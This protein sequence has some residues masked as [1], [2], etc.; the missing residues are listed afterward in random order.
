MRILDSFH[1][2]WRQ[3]VNIGGMT[4]MAMASRRGDLNLNLTPPPEYG[5]HVKEGLKYAMLQHEILFKHQ[6]R[7][8]H[9]LY[10]TQKR[11]MNE[12]R[13]S[14]TN[15][16]HDEVPVVDLVEFVSDSSDEIVNA[17]TEETRSGT[18]QYA[19]STRH[20]KVNFSTTEAKVNKASE[21]KVVED[22][23]KKKKTHSQATAS[24]IPSL[25]IRMLNESGCTPLEKFLHTEN[26][27]NKWR[28]IKFINSDVE[29]NYLEKIMLFDA[30]SF[31]FASI[32]W[33]SAYLKVDQHTVLERYVCHGISV[34]ESSINF[35]AD[36]L[37]EHGGS[38]FV[39][40]STEKQRS[41]Y[42]LT[43]IDLNIAQDDEFVN[44]FPDSVESSTSPSPK[45]TIILPGADLSV[46]NVEY[47]KGLTSMV[48]PGFLSPDL[49][50][51]SQRNA[52]SLHHDIKVSRPCSAQTSVQTSDAIYH[53]NYQG[54]DDEFLRSSI[55]SPEACC[56][57]LV[58]SI[59]NAHGII[60]Q[61]AADVPIIEELCKPGKG[62]TFS[63]L[64]QPIIS[65]SR[66]MV[67]IS[68]S[69]FENDCL[70]APAEST[71]LP[72]NT[73][74][75]EE[76]MLHKEESEEDTLSSH[77]KVAHGEQQDEPESR[78]V[79]ENNHFECTSENG[80]VAK[81]VVV[82]NSANSAIELDLVVPENIPSNEIPPFEESEPF[83]GIED[84]TCH[85]CTSQ[86]KEY[87]DQ[88]LTQVPLMDHIVAK[89]AKTL[90][91]ISSKKPLYTVDRL[92][93]NRKIES[94]SEQGMDQPQS[95]D[96]F[97][98]I[99]LK[100]KEIRD[101]GSSVC[102][103]LI[104]KDSRKDGSGY[105]LRRGLRDF[106][107]DILPGIVSLSR[108][109]ICEDLYAIK[110]ELNQSS[111]ISEGNCLIPIRSRRS[112]PYNIGRGC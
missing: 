35:L 83:L 3:G 85:F 15:S 52:S 84:R 11:L 46:S 58:E 57:D 48:Q 10:W 26:L 72:P 73:G 68:C 75:L 6:V 55:K 18:Y 88:R 93:S 110:Y 81:H 32:S 17:S 38:Q 44:G 63:L 1:G 37:E 7:E 14:R 21:L 28:N 61:H 66:S 16:V 99:T 102:D 31:V 64:D 94:E 65:D 76:K 60:T 90:V 49:R 8:L 100:L 40:S 107:K 97:E 106:Q 4:A 23:N 108:H 5:E 98:T 87:L 92:M 33:F 12:V 70:H 80:C 13:W 95:S 47:S 54:V 77:A 105:R 50:N 53:M 89:A 42:K 51:S 27:T 25:K 45:S 82:S 67:P 78:D 41:K 74:R 43:F 56:N 101:D 34:V 109:E 104:D 30:F 29:K 24:Y 19:F 62:S 36:R 71:N 9:R 103:K 111:R 20:V 22:A 2:R 69:Y 59:S 112:R 39:N 91:S 86:P 79:T 96:S